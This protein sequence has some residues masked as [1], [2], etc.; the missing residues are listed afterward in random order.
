MSDLTDLWG[1]MYGGGMEKVAAEQPA[2]PANAKPAPVQPAQA[3]AGAKAPA[4]PPRAPR[5]GVQDMVATGTVPGGQTKIDKMTRMM[6]NVGNAAQRQEKPTPPHPSP[7]P[8]Q[9]RELQA[10]SDRY[11]A[12]ES[13]KAD[14]YAG[15]GAVRRMVE[16]GLKAKRE[17]EA[18]LYFD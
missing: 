3:G 16:P 15:T 1:A 7:E 10:M 8:T 2:K 5:M 6:V 17:R 12:R 14:L 9:H 13:K 4:H 18:D 11:L